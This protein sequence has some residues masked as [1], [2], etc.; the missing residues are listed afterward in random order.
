MIDFDVVIVVK[1]FKL[2]VSCDRFLCFVVCVLFDLFFVILIVVDVFGVL[3]FG[4]FVVDVAFELAFIFL[5]VFMCVDIFVCG[6]GVKENVFNGFLFVFVFVI[7]DNG[8]IL[9]IIFFGVSRLDVFG[10]LVLL[11]EEFIVLFFFV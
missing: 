7:V 11:F 10:F 5:M 9:I 4:R 8:L 1:V 6:G 2:C 3:F